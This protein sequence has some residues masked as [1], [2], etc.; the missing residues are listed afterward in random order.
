MTTRRGGGLE[1]QPLVA[2]RGV[3]AVLGGA[4]QA[5]Q[6]GAHAA[7]QLGDADRLY[8]VVVGSG[9]ER[10]D[11]VGLGV[12]RREHHHVHVLV[13]QAQAAADL[14]AVDAG[15]EPDIEQHEIG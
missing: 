1:R 6:R 3:V 11:D 14:D 13:D 9:L 5:T 10:L 2:Q 12:E 4:P 8:D 7:A 15:A